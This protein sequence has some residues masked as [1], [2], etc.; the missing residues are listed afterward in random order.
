MAKLAADPQKFFPG[1]PTAAYDTP[2]FSPR[3]MWRRPAWLST[4][5]FALKGLKD[6]GYD[7]R[8]KAWPPAASA[9]PPPSPFHSSSIGI[10]TTSRGSSNLL[11]KRRLPI[12]LKSVAH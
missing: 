9:G 10:T 5:Y 4:S 8:E 3:D 7:D 11:K 6:Y 2:G 1:M 12:R